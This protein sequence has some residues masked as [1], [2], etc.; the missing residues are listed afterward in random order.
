MHKLSIKYL[1][2]GMIISQSVYHL[3]GT[4]LL[5]KGTRLTDAYIERLKKFDIPSIYV[6]SANTSLNIRPTPD[7]IQEQTRV[8]A[9][10][11]IFDTFKNCQLTNTVDIKLLNNTVNSIVHD[12]TENK[13]NLVQVS[14]IRLHDTYTFSHSVNVSVL[15]AMLA[16]KLNYP[17]KR[18]KEITLGGLLHDIGKIK[19]PN[20]ILNKPGALSSTELELIKM[21]P[22]DGFRILSLSNQFS[23]EVMHIAFEHHEKIDGT[24][25]PRNL[26]DN[27]IHEFSRIVAI[28]DVY[29]ALTSERAYKKPYK[30]YLAYNIMSKCSIGHFDADFLK[31][32]FDNIAIYQIG[33]ILNISYGYA[34]VSNTNL[35]NTLRPT[36]KLFADNNK[37]VFPA[38]INIDLSMEQRININH[39]LDEMQ[40]IDLIKTIKIDP[41]EFLTEY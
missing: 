5:T 32:F 11:D 3:N 26:T 13:T 6:T 12:L 24:G 15:A 41:V 25:Y 28:A 7:I 33:T 27:G 38:P 2:P 14:D 18:L 21:H 30:P 8:R 17:L 19:I 39:E 29:D 9:I 1:R 20:V 36:I 22:E 4:F 34:I 10:Q 40:L 37:K 31:I 23:P 35:G 16:T